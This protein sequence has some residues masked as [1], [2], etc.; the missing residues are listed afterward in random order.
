MLTT[1]QNIEQYT[2]D[3]PWER[4]PQTFQDAIQFSHSIGFE[5]LWIDSLCE[6]FLVV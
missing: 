1:T 6:C 4:L 3:I 5:Y 2:V